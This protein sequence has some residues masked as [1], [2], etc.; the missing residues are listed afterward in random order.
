[1][2]N[3]GWKLVEKV[4]ASEETGKYEE[5]ISYY[6]EAVEANP[7]ISVEGLISEV[8]RKARK[9][10]ET[11]EESVE[12]ER[13]AKEETQIKEKSVPKFS[14]REEYEKWKAGRIRR[15]DKKRGMTKSGWIALIYVVCLVIGYFYYMII[16]QERWA[17]KSKM[18][19]VT[20]PMSIVASVLAA[21]NQDLNSWPHCD[22]VIAIQNS[23][24]YI[25]PTQTTD[26]I[27]SITVASP[28]AE[29]V[30]ITATITGIDSRVDGKNVTLTGK[31]SERGIL[32]VWGGTVPSIYVYV[33]RKEVMDEA[34][35]AYIY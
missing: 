14:S 30:I 5:A 13:K 12:A 35:R 29:E 7:F 23:L 31:P 17:I 22:G 20:Y 24:G 11:P 3:K 9:E 27:S 21:Y 15:A 25:L 28:R 6:K 18:Y 32:W 2:K 19:S 33:P 34:S 16:Q 10:E 8:E 1:V 26:R 4:K